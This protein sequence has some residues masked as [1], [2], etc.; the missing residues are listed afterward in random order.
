MA[1]EMNFGPQWIRD[2]YERS[3]N[4]GTSHTNHTT[5]AARGGIQM[6]NHRYG[7]EEMV[8]LIP[9]ILDSFDLLH[10]QEFHLFE[11]REPS[12]SQHVVAPSNSDYN[13][14]SFSTSR[15][16]HRNCDNEF[17]RTSTN[18]GND[19]FRRHMSELTSDQSRDAEQKIG[20]EPPDRSETNVLEN[21]VL[22]VNE[23]TE[24]VVDVIEPV[25]EL[26]ENEKPE[27]V[28]CEEIEKMLSF[29][30]SNT[31][32][33]EVETED[34]NDNFFVPEPRVGVGI[35]SRE[36]EDNAIFNLPLPNFNFNSLMR[37]ETDN[38]TSA[39][40]DQLATD[41]I[42][43]QVESN[44]N[45]VVPDTEPG[46]LFKQVPKVPEV[47]VGNDPIWHYIDPR[48][49]EQG[50]FSNE[51]MSKWYDNNYFPDTLPI[52]TKTQKDFR[53]LKDYFAIYGQAPFDEE[54]S[55]HLMFA[56]QTPV[57]KDQE[58]PLF[59][60]SRILFENH[61]H[62]N[63]SNFLPS[64]P[65][66][67]VNL[68][69]EP[70][71]PN[72]FSALE[73]PNLPIDETIDHH[74][75]LAVSSSV[76]SSSGTTV[77][78]TTSISTIPENN[79][80]T[81]SKKTGDAASLGASSKSNSNSE[82]KRNKRNQKN[83]KNASNNDTTASNNSARPVSNGVEIEEHVNKFFQSFED[84]SANTK[85]DKPTVASS[86]KTKIHKVDSRSLTDESALLSSMLDAAC[87]K[88]K[89]RQP[90]AKTNKVSILNN[91]KQKAFEAP[92]QP[93]F[94]PSLADIQKEQ[95]LS[96]VGEPEPVQPIVKKEQKPTPSSNSPWN[97]V[98]DSYTPLNLS[99]LIN[100]S[101]SEATNN[102]RKA[103]DQNFSSVASV[104]KDF[105][106]DEFSYK[107][108]MQYPQMPKNGNQNA[109]KLSSVAAR[110]SE[111]TGVSS[112]KSTLFSNTSAV[113]KETGSKKQ[114]GAGNT[115]AA[116]KNKKEKQHAKSVKNLF[117]QKS[118]ESN[119]HAPEREFHG[120]CINQ[121]FAIDTEAAAAIDI[122]TFV[123]MLKEFDSPYEIHTTIK[124]YLGETKECQ[125]FASEFIKRK[126][127]LRP[128]AVKEPEKPSQ[129]APSILLPKV[130]APPVPVVQEHVP[131]APPKVPNNTQIS[132]LA[133]SNW[134][135]VNPNP[136]P[137][138]IPK[139]DSE[140][141]RNSKKGKQRKGQKINPAALLQISS[142]P[143]PDRVKIGEIDN[144]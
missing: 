144:A 43:G 52:R 64:G 116:K 135:S 7:Y 79:S 24:T 136:L 5:A 67:L 49:N 107:N 118:I 6:A 46:V 137:F 127:K 70:T 32:A 117:N 13:K 50:P 73:I 22:K 134:A 28:T 131:L 93:L 34:E 26:V 61:D 51:S 104:V 92:T 80:Q 57:I 3:V 37:I 110:H 87:A 9:S 88:E 20:K 101:N 78:N 2:M 15:N 103:P 68:N 97:I 72:H 59:Q 128:Q 18:R 58:S 129:V 55:A 125:E 48:G 12:F 27:P 122:P 4:E 133:S 121:V 25:P 105:E 62:T 120:W 85:Q 106:N 76:V 99:M 82:S 75:N 8:G 123:E 90:P 102:A 143:A 74:F 23:T 86:K 138:E 109:K 89:A 40:G 113:T 84:T 44:G 71:F 81:S 141:N 140:G 47:S 11:P 30:E 56:D 108:Q 66:E 41:T 19:S 130:V 119:L 100:S 38:S 39:M 95:K 21:G 36:L 31:S 98:H 112:S 1:T 132:V 77:A 17:E 126:N 16:K 114:G 65:T 35:D 139:L 45:Q 111:T 83:S 33:T 91:E 94:I 124:E 69:I 60:Q 96:N 54:C 53:P 142:K 42:D 14:N 63:H 115:A 29:H 10:G